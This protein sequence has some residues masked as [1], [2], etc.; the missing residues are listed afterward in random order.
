MEF[1]TN[2]ETT[3]KYI[4]V[5]GRKKERKLVFVSQTPQYKLKKI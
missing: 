3:W 4:F 5:G 1:L 2:P